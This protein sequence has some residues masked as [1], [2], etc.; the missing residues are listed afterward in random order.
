[1]LKSSKWAVLTA[2]AFV[3]GVGFTACAPEEETNDELPEVSSMDREDGVQE[4]DDEMILGPGDVGKA[5]LA[6]GW[7]EGRPLDNGFFLRTEH[8]RIVF[9]ESDQKVEPGEAVSVTGVVEK[10]VAESFN[11]WEM[12]ALGEDLNPDLDLWRGIYLDARAMEKADIS[13]GTSGTSKDAADKE[14]SPDQKY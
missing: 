12:E 9:V 7:V 14:P 1:M 13:T 3:T 11:A 10:S 4:L 6:T 5:I 2:A 8:K